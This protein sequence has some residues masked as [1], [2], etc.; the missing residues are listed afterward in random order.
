VS[1]DPKFH[2]KDCGFMFEQY[3]H[4]C[5]CG[6]VTDKVPGTVT[7]PKQVFSAMVATLDR[8]RHVFGEY[9][10]KHMAKGTEDGLQK[11]NAN[12]AHADDIWRVLDAV[13]NCERVFS[14][15]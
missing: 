11:A 7:I 15:D 1:H 9:G 10:R 2:A 4:E 6:Q 12:H 3:R 14:D 8:K 13:G 5:D